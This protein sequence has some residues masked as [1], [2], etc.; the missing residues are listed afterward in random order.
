M[1]IAE[2]DYGTESSLDQTPI[3]PSEGIDAFR[4]RA[5]PS[6]VLPGR[7]TTAEQS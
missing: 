3:E 2:T 5:R 1:L 6:L 7:L 4:A